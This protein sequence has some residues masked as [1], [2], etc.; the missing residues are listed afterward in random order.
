MLSTSTEGPSRAIAKSYA[1][2]HPR[3][4]SVI[5]WM[6]STNYTSLDRARNLLFAAYILRSKSFSPSFI[7]VL[8]LPF[9]LLHPSS[10]VVLPSINHLYSLEYIISVQFFYIFDNFIYL[11][12]L[13]THMNERMSWAVSID[14]SC[15]EITE[16]ESESEIFYWH[17][18][19]VN[20]LRQQRGH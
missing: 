11:I 10:V 1:K 19:A 15:F 8:Q 20:S 4:N 16:S 17:K 14:P 13:L 9:P 18:S 6:I 12:I 3:N 7:K 5:S 2:L